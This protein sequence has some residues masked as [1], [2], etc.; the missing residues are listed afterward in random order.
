MIG[1][2]KELRNTVMRKMLFYWI[3]RDL[4][5]HMDLLE[6]FKL[7]K[8]VTK[9]I[10]EGEDNEHITFLVDYAAAFVIAMY[11]EYDFTPD[12]KENIQEE[13]KFL[14]SSFIEGYDEA[15]ENKEFDL[16]TYFAIPEFALNENEKKLITD[17]KQAILSEHNL[18]DTLGDKDTAEKV[19]AVFQLVSSHLNGKSKRFWNPGLKHYAVV[20]WLIIYQCVQDIREFSKTYGVHYVEDGEQRCLFNYFNLYIHEI[21]FSGKLVPGIEKRRIMFAASALHPAEDDYIDR[22]TPN[23]EVI[24]ALRLRLQG[25]SVGCIDDDAQPIFTLVDLIYEAYPPESHPKLVEIFLALHDWQMTSLKQKSK[26]QDEKEILEISLMKGGYAFAFYGYMALGE[27]DLFQF[28]HFFGMG[29]IFQL[30]DDL[31]DI[32]KDREN[33]VETIWTRRINRDQLA[34]DAL[35]GVIG[36]QRTF[37]KMTSTL[38]T[39]RRPVFLRRMELFAARLDLGK[40]YLLNHKYFSTDVIDSIQ[41]RFNVDISPYAVQ[42]SLKLD[43]LK[44][45]DDFENMLLLLKSHYIKQVMGG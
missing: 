32:E 9:K 1:K 44:N 15:I 14:V 26:S 7:K 18:F 29:A 6:E 13:A 19:E 23:P 8:Y 25:K 10:D 22:K 27:M 38:P 34:D 28:R 21:L 31:H 30:M 12:V 35:L 20:M 17:K 42:Y 45:M 37:E 2:L 39:L 41:H 33:A 43:Q 5:K 3:E 16:L 36:V 40:F 4:N 11:S 24:H